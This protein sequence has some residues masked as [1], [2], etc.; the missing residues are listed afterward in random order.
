M[1][2]SIKQKLRENL[3]TNSLGV[4]I[5]RPNQELIIMRGIPGA[6]KS[7]KAKSLVREGVIHSTDDLID[8]TG[9]YR[10]FFAKMN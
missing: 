7:T 3:K 4:A 6:G 9:D 8:A 10:A 1:K 5:T 2:D